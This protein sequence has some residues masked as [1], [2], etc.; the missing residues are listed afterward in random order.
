MV[1]LQDEE[2]GKEWNG[3]VRSFPFWV[4]ATTHNTVIWEIFVLKIFVFKIFGLKN[5]YTLP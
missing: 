5:F 4:L 1:W 3:F 2:F